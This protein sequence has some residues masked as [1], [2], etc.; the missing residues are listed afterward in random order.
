MAYL[1][2]EKTF[3]P[4]GQILYV[5]DTGAT[6]QEQGPRHIRRFNIDGIKLT[7]GEVIA[8]CSK[9][10]FDG[11]RIDT[12]GH[13]WTSTGEGVHCLSADGELLGKI[14]VPEVV[15]NVCFG[16]YQRNR[17]FICASTT[18]YA[19]YLNVSGCPYPIK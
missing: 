19:T 16:G 5:A 6:H 4:D 8:E 14:H 15:A 2:L 13:I 12:L 3:S 7:G 9:G 10:L 18:L 1:G 17:L 11:F